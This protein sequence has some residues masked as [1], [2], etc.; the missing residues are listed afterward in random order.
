MGYPDR[1]RSP[2]ENPVDAEFLY[3]LGSVL[4]ELIEPALMLLDIHLNGPK[5]K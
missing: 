5:I 3:M 2:R 1:S 4:L